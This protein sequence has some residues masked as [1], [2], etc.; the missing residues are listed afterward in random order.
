MGL[1][2]KLAYWVTGYA[3]E[4]N[5]ESLSWKTFRPDQRIWNQGWIGRPGILYTRELQYCYEQMLD[6]MSKSYLIDTDT[7]R[8]EY[9]SL[10]SE[11]CRLQRELAFAKGE[12]E[13]LRAQLVDALDNQTATGR[14]NAI[15]QANGYDPEDVTEQ[16]KEG[17]KFT[18]NNGNSRL[19]NMKIAVAMK[20]YGLDLPTIAAELGIKATTAQA[21]ISTANKH[22][23]VL[24]IGDKKWVKFDA[25]YGGDDWDLD[26]MLGEI[27]Q[28]PQKEEAATLPEL[29]AVECG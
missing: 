5:Y 25:G 29:E 8:E 17:T 1:M 18:S 3:P 4:I 7:L 12:I 11:A 15:L 24:A 21:Y 19:E 2:A 28:K 14:K 22:Y 27:Y 13:N 20:E 23:E 6:E 26:E 16:K 9:T 10:N